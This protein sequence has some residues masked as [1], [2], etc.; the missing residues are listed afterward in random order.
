MQGQGHD[1]DQEKIQEGN[2]KKPKTSKPEI[3]TEMNLL[4]PLLPLKFG[5]GLLLQ[6]IVNQPGVDDKL[7]LLEV[8]LVTGMTSLALVLLTTMFKY[9]LKTATKVC[10][11]K[12]K[13]V[14]RLSGLAKVLNNLVGV[15]QV[16][17][18]V[19]LF[20]YSI[21]I[22]SKVEFND[23]ES[24]FYVKKRIFMFSLVVSFIM[25]I[26]ALVGATLMIIL[27]TH[28]P[29]PLSPTTTNSPTL[30]LG[31]ANAML[32]L[33]IG[34]PGDDQSIIGPKVILLDLCLYIGTV[35][36]FMTVL[37]SVI[38]VALTVA[39]RDGH[40][41]MEEATLLKYT[42]MARYAMVFLQVFMFTIMFCHSMEIFLSVDHPDYT[43]LRNLLIIADKCPP[44]RRASSNQLNCPPCPPIREIV[45]QMPSN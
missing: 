44:T 43:C 23:Q 6:Y 8:G 35:T 45:L 24:P 40:L 21:S 1:S 34:I 20:I 14:E 32:G 7:Y 36:V 11:F 3:Q 28:K 13:R 39:L 29:L 33:Y 42:Q 31:L 26:S 41:D 37:E 25:F 19:V 30:P 10:R 4:P 27:A 12:K 15:L 16:M 2:E 9:L 22:Y 38:K 18:L 5:N 17:L